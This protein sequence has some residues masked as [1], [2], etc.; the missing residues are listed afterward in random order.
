MSPDMLEIHRSLYEYALVAEY[1]YERNRPSLSCEAENLRDNPPLSWEQLQVQGPRNRIGVWNEFFR[2]AEIPEYEWYVDENDIPYVTCRREGETSFVFKVA[3][4]WVRVLVNG[5]VRD[6]VL[7]VVI[8]ALRTALDGT[9]E[10]LGYLELSRLD[11]D[12]QEQEQ[13]VAFRGTSLARFL[14]ELNASLGDLGD[15]GDLLDGSCTFELATRIV[16]ELSHRGFLLSVIGHSLGGAA[17]QHVALDQAENEIMYSREFNAYSFNS[18]G[19]D[20]PDSDLLSLP[21]LYSYSIDG[22]IVSVLGN[23]LG[24]NQ[25]GHAIRYIPPQGTESE[26]VTGVTESIRRHQIA[27][28]QDGLCNCLQGEGAIEER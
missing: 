20:V 14:P 19:L 18:V 27:A 3:L 28:V 12:G 16:A 23:E 4:T 26:S 5:E 17:T 21:R 8:V 6:V 1:A 24:R 22:E 9:Q 10:A 11:G 25:A 7:D 2:T 15:L 13:M